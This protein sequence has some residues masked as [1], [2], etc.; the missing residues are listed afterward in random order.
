MKPTDLG[1]AVQRR[2]QF[3]M[4]SDEIALAEAARAVANADALLIGAGAGMGVD[5]GMPDFRG[6][7]G[8]WKAYPPY[9]KLG[10]NFVALANPRWFRADPTLAWG[11]YGH[12]LHLYRAAQPHEG[13]QI[14]RRWGQRMAHGAFVYTSNVDGHF[15]RAGFDPERVMEV[16]GS[17]DYLQCMGEC[18]ADLFASDGI[19]I[20]I[21]ETTMQAREP[22]P[23][24]PACGGPARPNVLLFG[25]GEW[26]PRR[27][28]AQ[29]VRFNRWLESLGGARLAI[30]ECGAGMAI[31]TVRHLC[32]HVARNF[33]HARLIRINL[34]EPEVP[35]DGIGL[36]IGALEALQRINNRLDEPE[37]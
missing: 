36:A 27:G 7:Q 28:Y 32:E 17:L 4:G 14:L 3:T 9:Q 6:N 10:L 35:E 31:P 30:V 19:S 24:C 1:P 34:R 11:F 16:H 25:D 8:F 18:G 12:R 29:E 20:G 23:S 5:S 13:F 15:Q 37:A 22:L 26:D 33:R 21:D 2:T